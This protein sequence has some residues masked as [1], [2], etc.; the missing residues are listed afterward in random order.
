MLYLLLSTN[1]KEDAVTLAFDQ[2][3]FITHKNEIVFRLLTTLV[4]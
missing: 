2:I 3:L 1:N 4:K